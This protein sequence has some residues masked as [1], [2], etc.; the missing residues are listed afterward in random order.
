[1]NDYETNPSKGVLQNSIDKSD[2]LKMYSSNICCPKKVCPE[3]LVAKSKLSYECQNLKCLFFSIPGVTKFSKLWSSTMAKSQVWT[4]RFSSRLKTSKSFRC[5]NW[6]WEDNLLCF[7]FF[8]FFF[9]LIERKI[10]IVAK[11][12]WRGTSCSSRSWPTTYSERSGGSKIIFEIIH[13]KQP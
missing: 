11:A 5:N 2:S 8:F 9:F 12:V 10:Y 3:V 7:Y 1:M 6:Y 13:N 4:I